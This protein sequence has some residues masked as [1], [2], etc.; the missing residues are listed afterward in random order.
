MAVAAAALIAL[1]ATPGL[2]G[3]GSEPLAQRKAP[4]ANSKLPSIS[5]YIA[6]GETGVCGPGCDTW[7]AGEGS[8]ETGAAARFKRVLRQAKGNLPL[9]L[10]SPGGNVDEAIAIG[11]LLRERNMTVGVM[12]TVPKD[13]AGVADQACTKIRTSGRVA[14]LTYEKMMCNSSCVFVLLGARKRL[15]DPHVQL[16]IHGVKV[17]F[18]NA[19][20]REFDAS[21][22]P[23]LRGRERRSLAAVNDRLERYAR[24][25]TG[26]TDLIKASQLIPHERIKVLD[27][28]DIFKFGIDD[29][30]AGDSGWRF[31]NEGGRP[32][33]LDVVF[34]RH[35]VEGKPQGEAFALTGLTLTCVSDGRLLVSA[36]TLNAPSQFDLALNFGEDNVKLAP[37]SSGERR[38]AV[39]PADAA[40]RLWLAGD[41]ALS[42]SGMN[43]KLDTERLKS[44]VSSLRET[45]LP[46]GTSSKMTDN[47]PSTPGP[48]LVNDLPASMRAAI[49]AAANGSR[50]IAGGRFQNSLRQTS[51]LLNS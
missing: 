12:R 20:G 17:T 41:V 21:S 49:A 31:I 36:K 47:E 39:I 19:R 43:V 14:E 3:Q 28:G 24:E 35:V 40:T 45:C 44:A 2:A 51:R 10:S 1:A 42:V 18:T 25:M 15:L 23:E 26:R 38:S 22:R 33:V 8:I 7:I 16:G 11:R 29:R 50:P 6:K 46:A 5:F 34:H 13:C 48:T 37:A 4:R 27:R 9:I 32:H 30:D